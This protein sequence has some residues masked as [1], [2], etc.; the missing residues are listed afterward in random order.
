MLCVRHSTC[1]LTSCCSRFFRLGTEFFFYEFPFPTALFHTSLLSA[2]CVRVCFFRGGPEKH[3]TPLACT[4]VTYIIHEY[5]VY[6]ANLGCAGVTWRGG[7]RR[8]GHLLYRIVF[9]IPS[10]P[11]NCFYCSINIYYRREKKHTHTY[12]DIGVYPHACTT[13]P[14][15]FNVIHRI[16]MYRRILCWSGRPCSRYIQICNNTLCTY[17]LYDYYYYASIIVMII[18]RSSLRL[19]SATCWPHVHRRRIVNFSRVVIF[20]YNFK[21]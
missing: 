13:E 21:S 2:T 11:P 5:G 12:I 15:T 16:H 20:L 14:E 9:F 4:R 19:K 7:V 1:T 18:N 6:A 17:A 10:P 3:G 8:D